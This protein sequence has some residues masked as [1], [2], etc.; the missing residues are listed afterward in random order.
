MI[1]S[2][3][4]N[5]IIFSFKTRLDQDIGFANTIN[6]KKDYKFY[7]LFTINELKKLLNPK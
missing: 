4:Y 6:N 1:L 7:F 3:S 2:M 5:S